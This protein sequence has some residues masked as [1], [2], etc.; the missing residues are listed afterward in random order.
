MKKIF[1]LVQV[2][3]FL[4]IFHVNGQMATATFTGTGTCPTQGNSFSV[5][6]NAT[7]TPLTRAGGLICSS[8]MNVFNSS[9]LHATAT[10]DATKYIQ[11]SITA[12]AGFKVDLTSISFFRQGSNTAPN[13]MDVAYSVDGFATQT[14]W[15]LAPVTPT[16]GTVATWDFTDFSTAAGGTVTFRIYQYGTTRC[17]LTVPAA[18]SAGT[19]RVDD[20]NLNGSISAVNFPVTLLFFD[21]K[22]SEKRVVTTWAT[23]N[24]EENKGFFVQRSTDAAKWLDLGF[25]ASNNSNSASKTNYT[26]TDETPLSGI[27]YYRLRQVD[28]DGKFELSRARV[29]NFSI[30]ENITVFPNPVENQLYLSDKSWSQIKNL[31]LTDHSGRMIMA[32]GNG[33]SDIDFS[34]FSK[35]LYYLQIH[36]KDGSVQL[37]KIVK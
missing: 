3:T 16:S 30:E 21:A 33:Q 8:S 29:V 15:G 6:T 32:G 2:C 25:V 24:E 14:N 27:S 1:F 17:D 4:T 31:K 10:L 26:F 19:F 7:T 23:A 35:G 5:V 20:V 22:R 36:K 37:E 11:F 9:T 12:D 34:N 28:L 13:Q 18:S